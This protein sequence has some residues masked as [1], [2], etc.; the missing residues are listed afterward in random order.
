[1]RVERAHGPTNRAAYEAHHGD[2]RTLISDDH[3]FDAVAVGMGCMGVVC[4]ALLEV[5][6]KYFMREVREL[7]PWSK[8]RADLEDG[9]VLATTSTTSSSSARTAASTSTRAS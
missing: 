3:V 2:R 9:G 7:H 6:P 1:M 5:E 8:V 4:T